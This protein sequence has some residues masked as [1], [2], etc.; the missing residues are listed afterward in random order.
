MI[1]LTRRK[2]YAFTPIHTPRNSVISYS[3]HYQVYG[4]T[5]RRYSKRITIDFLFFDLKI[6]WYKEIII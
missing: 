2:L 6:Q 5:K 4:G 3:K 1:K